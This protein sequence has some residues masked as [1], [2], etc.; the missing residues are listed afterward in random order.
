[1]F[2]SVHACCLHVQHLLLSTN[3]GEVVVMEVDSKP[4]GTFG[5]IIRSH[6]DVAMDP[7]SG[8]QGSSGGACASW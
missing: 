1:M 5:S 4:D 3:N 2:E 8:K 7:L 6:V